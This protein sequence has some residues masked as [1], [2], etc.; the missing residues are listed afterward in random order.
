MPAILDVAIGT[1]FVF[2]L[3]SLVVSAF[4]EFILSLFDNRAKF[5][6]MGLNELLSMPTPETSKAMPNRL[7]KFFAALWSPIRSL[8]CA[9]FVRSRPNEW[10]KALCQHGLIDAFS[11]PSGSNAPSYIPSGAFVTALLDLVA[12]GKLTGKANANQSAG[13]AAPMDIDS[14]IKA[15]DKLPEGGLKQ[16]L[17]SLASITGRDLNAFKTALEGWFN[18]SMDRAAGWYKRFSQKWM[19]LIGFLLAAAINVDSIHVINVLSTSPNLAKAVASQAEA[20]SKSEKPQTAEATS[21]DKARA[22]FQDSVAK[23][24]ATGIPIGWNREELIA[25][26]LEGKTITPTTLWQKR[27]QVLSWVSKHRGQLF[28]LLA[29]WALTAAAASVGAPFWFDLLG[30]FVNI[31]NNGKAPT[32]KDPTQPSDAPVV[33]ALNHTPHAANAVAPAPHVAATPALP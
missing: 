17:L 6:Q 8:W 23:L 9:F 26:D 13:N 2:L 14:L 11:R 25:L 10:T 27:D 33:P 28:M 29:G 16:S 15:I 31:R 1:I 7:S 19:L 20:Y 30:R 21:I 5:L 24:S 18:G 12:R 32:D 4:N 3:F 22:D